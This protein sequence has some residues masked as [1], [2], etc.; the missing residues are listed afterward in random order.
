LSWI[1]DVPAHWQI[2][3][4]GQLFAQRKETG[5]AELPILEVSLHTG[6]RIRK[7][8][9]T[10]RKQVMSDRSKYKRAAKG[11]IAYNMMRMWQG[12]VG[13]VPENGLVSPAYV[14][15]TPLAGVESK[16]FSELF[17]TAAYRGEVDVHSHGIVKDRN[18]LYWEDFKQ[19]F[20][21]CPPPDEQR[22]IIRYVE[23]IDRR[24]R[25]LLFG[26]QQL[27]A[28]LQEHRRAIVHRAVTQGFEQSIDLRDSGVQWLGHIP[29][30]W[31][32]YRLKYLITSIEQG[33]SPQC[34]A[35][36]AGENEWGVLK[37]GCV[38]RVYF[39]PAQNKR[40]PSTLS[41]VPEL[42]IKSGDIL[43]SRA[44]T[45]ELLGLAA[46]VTDTRSHLLLCD[47]LFRFRA[48][49][50]RA[51]GPFIVAAIRDKN[52]R[53]QIEASTNGASDS[54]QNIGQAVVK[55]LWLSVPP[56]GEQKQIVDRFVVETASI[57]LVIEREQ[58]ALV[59]LR[60]YRTRLVTDVVTGQLDVR[61]AAASL[62]DEP[63]EL[64]LADEILEEPDEADVGMD[65]IVEEVAE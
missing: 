35:Q 30:H 65:D 22:A 19:I 6:V 20:S 12:A 8:D 64:S 49:E 40:L 39:D 26:K 11:D 31:H 13:V 36:P 62:P 9:G 38:N 47:K 51:Y 59:L 43:M 15:A 53:V 27:L 3:R 56:V 34:D 41:A 42:E 48:V 18:R 46:I 52:S 55:N 32:P 58:K 24:V 25:Q 45:R 2:R 37:V 5:F 57:D 21:V 10:A 23:Y 29:E 50:H 28:M 44:N 54:M 7:F 63:D 14:V 33:W 61:E 17:C 4:N 16:Y 1:G 60:E